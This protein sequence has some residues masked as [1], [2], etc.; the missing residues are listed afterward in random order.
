MKLEPLG[1]RLVVR[2]DE[3]VTRTKGGL[4][5]PDSAK[6]R[7]RTGEVVAA[8]PGRLRS[9]EVVPMRVN[10]GDRVLFGPY[11]GTEI[12]LG[13]EQFTLLTEEEVYGVLRD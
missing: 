6:E 13:D 9:G 4:V 1:D 7:P 11:A 8:G 2:R 3:A 10:V 5:L 12:Q